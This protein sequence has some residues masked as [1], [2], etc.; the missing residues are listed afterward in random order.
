[1]KIGY[2]RVS[3]EEQK[4]EGQLDALKKEGCEQIFKEKISGGKKER[5][6]LERCLE[7]LREGDT[8]VVKKLDRLGR[9]VRQL[10]DLI[11]ILKKR[12]IHF[13]CIDDPIDTTSS[14][15]TFF[16]HVMGAFAELEKNLIR[17]RTQTGLS[18]ARARGRTGGRPETIS[19]DKK[20]EAYKMYKANDKTVEEIGKLLGM[21][22]MTIYRFIEKKKNQ[23]M[24]N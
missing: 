24:L 8:L 21:S 10:V 6:E 5:E 19:K 22:R 20:E 18:A 1:M 17:E 12:K 16:F 13:K 9:T 2:A 14:T 15:G 4:L 23:V 3:T 7:L 11:E